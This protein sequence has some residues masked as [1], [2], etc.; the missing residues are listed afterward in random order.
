MLKCMTQM[1][2]RFSRLKKRSIT[3]E[4]PNISFMLIYNAAKK[5]ETS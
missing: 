3:A 2:T 1:L 4:S 5:Y